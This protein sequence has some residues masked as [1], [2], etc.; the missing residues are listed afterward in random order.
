MKN[1][2]LSI[3]ILSLL[4]ACSSIDGDNDDSKTTKSGGSLTIPLDSYFTIERPRQILKIESAQIYGQVLESLVKFDDKTLEVQPALAEK[5]DV[6]E[7]G[8]TYTFYLRKNVVFHDNACF[9][10]SKGREVTTKDIVNMFY[11]VYENVPENSAYALF[12]N[13]IE[14]GDE[15]H[16]NEAENIKGISSDDE[17]VTV[18]LTQPK[19]TFLSKLVTIFASIIP[20]EAIREDSWTIVGTGPFKYNKAKSTSELVVLNKNENYWMTDSA[21]TKLP[22]LDQLTYKFY[23]DDNARM[24][25]FWAN[26]ISLLKDVP[27]TKVSEVLEERIEDFQGKKAK[28]VLESVPQMSTTYLEFNMT[29][30]ALKDVRVRQAINYAIDRKKIVEKTLKNQAYEIGKFGITPPL[31]KIYKGYDFEGIEDYGYTRNSEK[32]KQLLADAGYPDGKNFPTLSIQFKK[33]N[34]RYLVMSEV[35]TQLKS[36]LNIDVDIEQVE[37]NKLLENEA[38]GTADIFHNVWIGDFPSP[39]SFLIN[40]YGNLVPKDRN[41]P[42]R[43]NNG[44]YINKEFDDLFEKGMEAKNPKEA[45]KYYAEAEKI[46]LQNPPLVVLYY[47]ENLWL[48]QANIKNFHTNGMNY[49][50]FTKVYIDQTTVKEDHS[51]KK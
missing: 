23:D 1:L 2:I 5:W 20:E 8:L 19:N 22:Y 21:G 16:N 43:I 31:P 33:D 40:F 48:R 29:S 50:D 28:Y 12:Q 46:M 36:V 7:D 45:N 17:T 14:G 13:T 25:D 15:Y 27:I 35:Q 11:R 44:R 24:D 9:K 38:H 3:S 34:S 37:F 49:I 18:T 42:S 6:S 4:F 39:E 26:K 41:E 30:K 10:D 32:A 47:G 51:T